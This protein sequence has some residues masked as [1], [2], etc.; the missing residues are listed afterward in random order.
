MRLRKGLYLTPWV[1]RRRWSK[2]LVWWRTLGPNVPRRLDHSRMVYHRWE[3]YSPDPRHGYLHN[4][5]MKLL[6]INRS[7]GSM[8]HRNE[9]WDQFSRLLRKSNWRRLYWRFRTVRAQFLPRSCAN[10]IWFDRDPKC[11]G[12]RLDIGCCHPIPVA[13][14]T[15]NYLSPSELS[16]TPVEEESDLEAVFSPDRQQDQ[17]NNDGF[18]GPVKVYKP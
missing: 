16:Q 3:L 13:I 4:E 6:A 8:L 18:N 2:S 15:P 5:L 14:S 1:G 12:Y 10:L 7:H 11:P 17:Q 9:V